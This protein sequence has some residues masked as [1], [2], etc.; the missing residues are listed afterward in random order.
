[1]KEPIVVRIEKSG[2]QSYQVLNNLLV[3]LSKLMEEELTNE[4]MD[5]IYEDDTHE[6]YHIDQGIFASAELR[7]MKNL[8]PEPQT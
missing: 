3:P 2:K 7:V 8:N 6:L 4:F 5:L 1:M